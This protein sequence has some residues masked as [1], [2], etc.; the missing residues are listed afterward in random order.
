MEPLNET[1]KARRWRRAFR[2]AL[3]ATIPVLTGFL[4]IGIAYGLLMQTKGY[5][6][7][8]SALMSGIAFCGSMQFVAIG[9]L[10]TA[11]DPLQAFLLSLMVNARHLFYGL[12]MLEKY[13]G[14][15]KLRRLFVIYTMCDENFS[16]TS[17]LEP[18]EEV[19]RGDFY[20]CLCLLNYGYWIAASALGGL[21]G[22][23]ITFDTTGLDFAL[24]ALFVV[25]FLEQWKKR[26]NR[27][28][29][30]IGVVCALAALA[31]FGPDNMIIPAMVL[32]VAALL[33]G[34][35]KLCT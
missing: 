13:K 24:S 3:P 21:L 2:A 17:T 10:T 23:L 11:F 34:R 25:L 29:G 9:L 33:A 26:E 12:S 27:P 5:G 18:P 1:K 14:M 4:C 30:A 22:S 7:V 8:W 35:R 32:I 28:S 31:A 20:F 16:L 19:D 15:G 6:P